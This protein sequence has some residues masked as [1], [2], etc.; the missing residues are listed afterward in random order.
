MGYEALWRLDASKSMKVGSEAIGHC[1]VQERHPKVFQGTGSD[2]PEIMVT[3]RFH[4]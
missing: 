3:P 4:H 1:G 2:A